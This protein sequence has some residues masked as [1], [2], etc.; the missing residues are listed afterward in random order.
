[1]VEEMTSSYDTDGKFIAGWYRPGFVN[2]I[3]GGL[4]I[5]LWAISL[6]AQVGVNNLYVYR[7]VEDELN[8][9]ASLGV[10]IKLGL[11]FIVDDWIKI[12]AY[13]VSI[14]PSFADVAQIAKGIFDAKTQKF[15]VDKFMGSM[16]P[17]IM[18]VVRI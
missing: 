8:I 1:M 16:V 9:D 2:T 3:G 10:H 11:G 7:Q 12:Q 15:A 5:N 17:A 13:L 18:L 6:G 4:Q 14:Q